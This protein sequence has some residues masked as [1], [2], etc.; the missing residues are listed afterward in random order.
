MFTRERSNSK[1]LS[2]IAFKN[3]VIPTIK[4]VVPRQYTDWS[5]VISD[6]RLESSDWNL[7]ASI[8]A[9]F[10]SANNHTLK[11][12]L[13]FID[14]NS[15]SFVINNKPTKV[16]SGKSVSS[17]TDTTIKWSENQGVL[18]DITPQNILDESYS[19][20]ITWTLSDAP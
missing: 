12:A 19:T 6:S 18:L 1:L 17:P 7:Y 2:V 15:K 8:K 16:Y 20:T 13:V 10:T 5:I 4:T 3:T 11:D 9:P 14:E